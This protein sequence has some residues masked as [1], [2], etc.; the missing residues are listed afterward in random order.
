MNLKVIGWACDHAAYELKEY[1]K[2][3]LDSNGI[4]Y[5]DYGCLSSESVA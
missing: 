2:A 3:V 4:A 1:L 5:K